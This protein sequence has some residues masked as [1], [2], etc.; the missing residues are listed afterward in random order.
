MRAAGVG[1]PGATVSGL[2]SISAAV[3]ILVAPLPAPDKAAQAVAALS[4]RLRL[5][6]VAIVGATVA[7]HRNKA[8]TAVHVR[9]GIR[10]VIVGVSRG[11]FSGGITP[12][13]VAGSKRCRIRTV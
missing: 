5:A 3:S 2:A 6:A 4:P 12:Q 13:I 8:A 7:L 1:P 9:A 11:F 10:L